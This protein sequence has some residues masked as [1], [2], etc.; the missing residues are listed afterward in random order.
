MATI[1]KNTKQSAAQCNDLKTDLHGQCF[2]Y[3]QTCH[4]TGNHTF[5]VMTLFSQWDGND[6]HTLIEGS[7]LFRKPIILNRWER[8]KTEERVLRLEKTAFGSLQR[9]VQRCAAEVEPYGEWDRSRCCSTTSFCW[10][11][12]LKLLEKPSPLEVERWEEFLARLTRWWRMW[13]NHWAL[14]T[15]WRKFV[16]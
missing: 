2:G 3:I 15:R 8:E 6:W 14:N 13:T 10:S 12:I 7:L 4:G 16:G 1:E 9:D 5:L 11:R